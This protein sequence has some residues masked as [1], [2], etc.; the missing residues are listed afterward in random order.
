M[1]DDDVKNKEELNRHIDNIL[2]T[3]FSNILHYDYVIIYNNLCDKYI[4][5]IFSDDE[6]LKKN[7][8]K[9]Y[10]ALT[11]IKSKYQK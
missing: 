4:E 7:R 3:D 1:R 2:K 6:N 10:I 9:Y 5:W 11:L 8:E